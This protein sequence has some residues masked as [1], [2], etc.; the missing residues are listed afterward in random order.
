NDAKKTQ[1]ELEKTLQEAENHLDESK[2]ITRQ[3]ICSSFFRTGLL[4]DVG[5]SVP[6]KRRC[7]LRL[8]SASCRIQWL[9]TSE[10]PVAVDDEL[11]LQSTH[12][13]NINTY[14]DA[15]NEHCHRTDHVVDANAFPNRSSSNISTLGFRY[16]SQYYIR[17]LDAN[18]TI[19]T[20][21][22][23]D[24][25]REDKGKMII[26]EPEITA[27]SDLRPIHCNKT[28]EA[29]TNNPITKNY[30]KQGTP[31]QANMD[32]KDADYFDQLLQH[33]KAYRISGFS[34]E[35]TGLWERT[36]DN[37]TSLIFQFCF[38]QRVPART[39]VNHT[40]LTD[41]V[42]RIQAVSRIYTSGDATTNRARRRVI[43]I[44]NLRYATVRM[45]IHGVWCWRT[46]IP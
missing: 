29:V 4:P 20:L 12:G 46:A 37:P 30:I 40:I 13:D 39:N 34:C 25:T 38:L 2:R 16:L 24:S 32:V 42:S 26:A 36:L 35:Q 41:Y 23:L 1:D 14:S 45:P 43:D 11:L 44:Q 8:N 18:R 33:R 9:S 17:P 7:I 10:I 15:S 3:M 6:M 22:K 27:I 19:A 31:I 21:S 28:I 5:L